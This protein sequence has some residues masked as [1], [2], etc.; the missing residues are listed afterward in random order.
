MRTALAAATSTLTAAAAVL[1]LSAAP[2]H[3]ATALPAHVYAPYFEAWNGQDPAALAKQAGVKYLS[4]AFLQTAETGSCTAYW[5]GDSSQPIAAATFGSSIKSIQA[6]GGDVIPSFGGYTA[7]TT[8]TDIADSCTSV[9]SIAAVYEKLVTTYNV[10]RIDLDV[11]QDSLTNSAGIDRRNKAIAQVESWAA[12]NGRTVQ[13]SYTL[14]TNTDGLDSGGRAVLA[15]AVANKARIDVVNIMTFDYY[16]G[17][18]IEMAKAT[19]TAGQG[20]ENYLASLY[21]GKSA[22]QLW[23]MVGVTEMQ[24]ID[25]YG[26]AE[27]FTTADAATVLNWA[28]SKGINELSV[29]ALQR[30]NGGCVGTAGSD[31]CS[32]IG[33]SSWYFSHAFEPFTG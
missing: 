30:D 11:E 29:W 28:K 21:P 33:Q 16:T 24:G 3:A 6:A 9:S 26:K 12:A 2:A 25:D 4:M 20:L 31:S 23:A 32:G 27:T 15:N 18:T 7:D 14:P 10:H 1:G 8:K 13:F 19:E 17:A 5:N 22:T